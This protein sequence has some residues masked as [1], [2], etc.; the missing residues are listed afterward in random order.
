MIVVEN[1]SFSFIFKN[2]KK[3]L[4]GVETCLICVQV[5]TDLITLSVV[6]LLPSLGLIED[7]MTTSKSTAD[8][9]EQQQQQKQIYINS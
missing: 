3:C 9:V 4:S 7:C 6:R 8:F 5:W 2:F 1:S